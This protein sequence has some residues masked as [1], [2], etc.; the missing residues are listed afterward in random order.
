MVGCVMP[1]SK[2]VSPVCAANTFLPDGSFRASEGF[3]RWLT[4]SQTVETFQV[5]AI[6]GA[7]TVDGLDEE[8]AAAYDAP[9]VGVPEEAKAA[10]RCFPT[11][12]PVSRWHPGAAEN[13]AFWRSLRTFERPFVTCFSDSDPVSRGGDAVFQQLVAGAAG[14]PHTTIRGGGHFLQEDRGEQLATHVLRV[15][16]GTTAPQGQA[17]QAKL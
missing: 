10:A 11:L 4:F 1:M 3:Q 15:A 17:R 12:V 5:G 13:R 7:G 9:F 16:C 6:I 8:V 14:Q 2:T